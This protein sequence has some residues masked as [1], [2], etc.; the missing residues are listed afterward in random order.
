[1]L[2]EFITGD[3]VGE[4]ERDGRRVSG[5]GLHARRMCDGRF[6][7][8]MRARGRFGRRVQGWGLHSRRLCDGRFSWRVQCQGL[9]GSRISYRRLGY[10]RLGY[11]S[12]CSMFWG[13]LPSLR[14]STSSRS[15][16]KNGSGSD[17]SVTV[18][19]ENKTM[20]SFLKQ[21]FFS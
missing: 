21:P 12:Q 4:S 13:G 15:P 14:Q 8:M 16:N 18:P 2:G 6:I 20:C 10:M 9:C 1:M 11:G 7:R 17:I 5:W 19:R 3:L